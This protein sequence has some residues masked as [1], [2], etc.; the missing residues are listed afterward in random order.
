MGSWGSSRE[1]EDGSLPGGQPQDRRRCWRT[2][3]TGRAPTEKWAG[4]GPS[5]KPAGLTLRKSVW[6]LKED[7]CPEV[8]DEESASPPLR[9]TQ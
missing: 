2:G 4:G 8:C 1:R 7:P 6:K 3:L 5:E 9:K